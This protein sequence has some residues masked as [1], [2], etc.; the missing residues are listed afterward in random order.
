MRLI[1]DAVL[2]RGEGGGLGDHVFV[3][4]CARRKS[5]YGKGGEKGGIGR[6]LG[7]VSLCFALLAFL[8]NASTHPSHPI[9]CQKNTKNQNSVYIYL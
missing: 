7:G 1:R 9:Q 8:A 2:R 3:S 4:G 6:S 5:A